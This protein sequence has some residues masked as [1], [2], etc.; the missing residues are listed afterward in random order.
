M[1]TPS[2]KR[3]LA[4]LVYEALSLLAVLFIAGFAVV[5]LQP[6]PLAGWGLWLHRTYLLAVAGGYFIWFWRHGGQT[7]AMKTWRIRLVR[8]DGGRIGLGQAWLRY[9]LAVLGALLGGFGFL[10]ALWD[11]ERQF[12]H[13]RLAGTRL[14]LDA[15]VG[16]G[17]AQ[18][19]QGGAAE[20]H[21]GQ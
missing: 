17:A 20:H 6:E 1:P 9:L 16:L 21:Q 18:G 13:D 14:I 15:L 2:L 7:L 19:D 3:R 11:R 10:W 5:G 8:I 12:L 4:C